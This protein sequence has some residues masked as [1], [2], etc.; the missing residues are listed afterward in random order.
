MI[1]QTDF[2]STV[3]LN[4]NKPITIGT[5]DMPGSTHVMQIQVE[6]SKLP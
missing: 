1:R 5:V 2:K 6:L 3:L 4:E